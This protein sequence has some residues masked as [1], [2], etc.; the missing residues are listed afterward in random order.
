MALSDKQYGNLLV[1][2]C[3]G[4]MVLSTV[5]S[6]TLGFITSWIM[7]FV[8]QVLL[9]FLSVYTL[10]LYMD[11]ED[12]M[13]YA[14]ID[15]AKQLNPLY[16]CDVVMRGYHILHLTTLWSY[17]LLL[18]V[19]PLFAYDLRQVL[20]GKYTVDPSRLWKDISRFKLNSQ[21]KL[22]VNALLFFLHLFFMLFSIIGNITKK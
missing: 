16:K 3:A 6:L 9:G 12:N 13:G 21:L 2:G 20:T 4:F 5:M 7:V 17:W 11:Y 8:L 10:L 15:M 18:L 19:V 1:Y 14:A 22:G